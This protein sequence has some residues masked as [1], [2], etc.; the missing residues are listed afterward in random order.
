MVVPFARA[1]MG[2]GVHGVNNGRAFMTTQ[3]ILLTSIMCLRNLMACRLIN[4]L[5]F[6]YDFAGHMTMYRAFLL[7][8]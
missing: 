4:L 6:S 7:L 5:H 2:P 1:F 8:F 3:G